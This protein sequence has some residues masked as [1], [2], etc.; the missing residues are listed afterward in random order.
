MNK[1]EIGQK[2]VATI[3]TLSGNLVWETEIVDVVNNSKCQGV[4]VDHPELGKEDMLFVDTNH[5]T[6]SVEIISDVK[7]EVVK[8]TEMKDAK[9][10]IQDAFKWEEDEITVSVKVYDCFDS[11]PENQQS[12]D[13]EISWAIGED[14]YTDCIVSDSFYSNLEGDEV[15]LKE[16]TKRAKAV[17]RTVK[18][19]FDG[20]DQVTVNNDV[21]VYHV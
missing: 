14:T 18:G 13:V 15:S 16:A 19:W 21:E 20:S 17:L 7:R 2:V 8:G 1:F 3:K 9:K 5:P 6:N 11:H 4:W 12:Y 10:A